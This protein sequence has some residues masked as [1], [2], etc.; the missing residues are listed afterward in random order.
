VKKELKNSKTSEL[1][2]SEK[3]KYRF[4]GDI[5]KDRLSKCS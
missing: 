1:K 4:A 3:S 2:N 5:V